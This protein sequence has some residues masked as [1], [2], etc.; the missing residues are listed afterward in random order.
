MLNTFVPTQFGVLYTFSKLNKHSTF[1][2]STLFVSIQLKFHSFFQ[3]CTNSELSIFNTFLFI[4]LILCLYTFSKNKLSTFQCSLHFATIQFG[5]LT[6][7]E[8]TQHFQCYYTFSSLSTLEFIHFYPPKTNSV[9]FNVQN[10]FS[11]TSYNVWQPFKNLLQLYNFRPTK[12][13]RH[14]PNCFLILYCMNSSTFKAFQNYPQRSN[15]PSILKVFMVAYES[16]Q[17]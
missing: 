14:W 4:L 12:L 10:L 2:C 6:L 7:S 3:R 16:C 17:L 1:Q 5:V 13:K 9:L 11:S 15:H 8:Q